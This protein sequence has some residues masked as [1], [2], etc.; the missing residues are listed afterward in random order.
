M[1]KD[2]QNYTSQQIVVLEGLEPVRKRPA[3]YIG[4]TDT[5][6]LHHCV[7]EIVDNSNDE[8]LAGFAKNVW[9]IVHKDNSVSVADDG[10]GIP[11][12]IM[13]KYNK[14]ALE[15]IMTTLHSGGKFEGEAYKISGGLHGVGAACVNALSNK[16]RVEVRRE[17][18]IQFMEFSKGKVVTK[19]TTSDKSIYPSIDKLV[20]S[21]IDGTT[22]TFLPDPEIFKE[23]LEFDNKIIIK[24]LKDRAYLTS[25]IFFHFFDERSSTQQHFYFEGGIVSLLREINKNKTILHEPIYLHGSD[26]KTNTDVEIAIQY[27]DSFQEITPSFVNIVNTHE[28]GSHLSGFKSALTRSIK[29]YSVKKELIKNKDDSITGDDV[30]EGL[31][32]V[33][34]VR[35][36]SKDLQFEGQTKGRLGNSE[37][38][39]IVAKIVKDELDTFFEE[40]PDIAKIIVG[41]SL[42]A[43]QIRKAAR[44][45]KDAIMRKGAFD[46][47][48]LPG[49]LA[50][51]Q[52]KK[53]EECEIYIVEGD[54]AG[55]SA[56]Q[57]RDRRFQAILPLWGKALNTEGMRLDKVVGSDKLKD[58]II[59]LGMGIGE[60]LNPEKLRY[61]RIILM[62]DADVDGAHISAL[63][64]TFLFRHLPYTIEN[65]Y[66]YIAMPPL[67][68][69][70]Q[71]KKFK[72]VYTDEE[73][74]NYLKTI[75][76]TK[77]ID[78]Q[79]YKGLG[80]MN[81]QQLWETTM[82]PE[83][84]ILKKVTIG[85]AAK[86]DETFSILM[87]SNVP[88]RK[89]FIQTHAHLATLD[90]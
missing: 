10:R 34:A 79:R 49:K 2:Q 86:A 46:S 35:M 53:P 74:E 48:G 80:E 29:D 39:P 45:A 69:I 51:C 14:P 84:R 77:T 55:G 73:K 61:H 1:T 41:K 32:A 42:L 25:K 22:V 70:S 68:K 87:S 37:V 65:G 52:S 81:P 5:T 17:K 6:G 11:V 85:D 50:D 64:L 21:T 44:A 12:D 58:F 26:Q 78:I 40:H 33:I 27:N 82:N 9:V 88:P 13:P 76:A 57:G 18:K 90:I 31:T 72:Y 23:T 62:A 19:L 38:Q 54:S 89:K 71:G 15:V 66:V 8:A 83:T 63:L 75:D 67:Y 60:T 16:F 3:M 59:A 43:I 30:R 24:S 4:S 28:G 47:L 56:K 36:P 20:P 7:S